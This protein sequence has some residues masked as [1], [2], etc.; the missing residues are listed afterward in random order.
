MKIMLVIPLFLIQQN[1]IKKNLW[2]LTYISNSRQINATVI[3]LMQIYG[4][5]PILAQQSKLHESKR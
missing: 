3:D 4:A 1:G 2:Y 5:M